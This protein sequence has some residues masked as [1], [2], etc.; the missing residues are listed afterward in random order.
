MDD[1]EETDMIFFET[2]YPDLKF[3]ICCINSKDIHNVVSYEK[4]IILKNTYTCYCYDGNYKPSDYIIIKS[5]NGKI[6]Y[7]DI[8]YQLEQQNFET[9]CN[10]NFLE[11]L[12]KISNCEYE[13]LF[14]S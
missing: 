1:I 11:G 13:M 9:G 10:H 4:T 14:G 12:N 3:S 7:H 8:F 5:K 6:T 2:E